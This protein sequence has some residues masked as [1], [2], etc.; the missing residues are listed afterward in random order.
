MPQ[1]KIFK[2]YGYAA[3][4]AVD[5]LG[6][7]FLLFKMLPQPGNEMQIAT[8]VPMYLD[9][10]TR[11]PTT[12]L[13]KAQEF[14]TGDMSNSGQISWTLNVAVSQTLDFEKGSDAENL[15]CVLKGCW[16]WA[17]EELLPARG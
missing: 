1:T 8:S 3:S 16:D 15:G 7:N 9:R 10:E 13:S 4:A 11:R 5:R 6:V 17:M 2:Y 12:Q 14:L